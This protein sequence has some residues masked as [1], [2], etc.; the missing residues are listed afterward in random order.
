MQRKTTILL[1][2]PVSDLPISR[3][4]SETRILVHRFLLQQRNRTKCRPDRSHSSNASHSQAI[5]SEAMVHCSKQIGCTIITDR[6]GFVQ[7]VE[8]RPSDDVLDG[9]LQTSEIKRE[10]NGVI[11][12]SWKVCGI[13]WSTEPG[14]PCEPYLK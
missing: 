3:I 9:H 4:I 13:A 10:P 5:H 8:L 14:R 2:F 12:P 11:F 6:S 1:R 7:N